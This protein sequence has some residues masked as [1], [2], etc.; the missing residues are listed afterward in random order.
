MFLQVVDMDIF[1]SLPNLANMIQLQAKIDDS[2]SNM[3]SEENLK[4]ARKLSTRR[5]I[6]DA[7]QLFANIDTNNK[8]DLKNTLLQ[9]IEKVKGYEKEQDKWKKDINQFAKQTKTRVDQLLVDM[10][11]LHVGYNTDDSFEEINKKT[12][13][14]FISYIERTPISPYNMGFVRILQALCSSGFY[15]G[16]DMNENVKKVGALVEKN[17]DLSYQLMIQY[18]RSENMMKERKE[19]LDSLSHSMQEIIETCQKT[20]N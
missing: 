10:N 6:M 16:Y 11:R 1:G 14:T 17:K 8:E 2:F 3:F 15:R 7:S 18:G 13:E 12:S 19:Q 4:E 5:P 9:N 20:K